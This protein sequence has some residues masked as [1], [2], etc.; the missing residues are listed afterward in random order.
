M[1]KPRFVRK[2]QYNSTVFISPLPWGLGHAARCIPLIKEFLQSNCKVIIGATGESKALLN[3]QF[4]GLQ[5][6][7][8]KGYNIK[9]SNSKHFFPFKIVLQ[10]PAIIHAI[11]TEYHQ[12]K[13]VIKDHKI[14]VVVSDNRPGLYNK[15]VHSIYI[16]HQLKIKTGSSF[17][18]RIINRAHHFFIKKF[19]E[20]WVPDDENNSIAGELSFAGNLKNVKYIGPISRLIPKEGETINY[21]IIV[22]LSGPEPQRTILESL[23]LKQLHQTQYNVFFVRG[24]NIKIEYLNTNK[25]VEVINVLHAEELNEKIEQSNLVICRSGYTSIMDLIRLRKRAILIA[26]PG[27]TEQEYL[28]LFHQENGAFLS[29]EQVDFNLQKALNAVESFEWKFPAVNM[30]LY[31]AAIENLMQSQFNKS[32]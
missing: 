21:D 3:S 2:F 20:C 28:A 23:L 7:E 9:Y 25:R 18:G 19:D 14:T 8:L 6:I 10:L 27:Q 26:T 12:L 5:I 13:R 16:T 4:P 11:L 22:V 24:S 17:T 32:L 1:V 29:F 30:E 15:S 31:K